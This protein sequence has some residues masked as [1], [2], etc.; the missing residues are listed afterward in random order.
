MAPLK[1]PPPLMAPLKVKPL[2]TIYMWWSR[3]FLGGVIIQLGLKSVGTIY[4]CDVGGVSRDPSIG[5]PWCQ[6][7]IVAEFP[8]GYMRLLRLLKNSTGYVISF[9]IIITFCLWCRKIIIY[10]GLFSV[11]PLKNSVYTLKFIYNYCL[12][13]ILPYLIKLLLIDVN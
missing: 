11:K 6:C 4:W 5:S 10:A 1:N 8:V 13:I 2:G 12:L 7:L 3:S 9:G